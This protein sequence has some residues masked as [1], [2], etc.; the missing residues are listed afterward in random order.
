MAMSLSSICFVF[1]GLNHQLRI[2]SVVNSRRLARTSKLRLLFIHYAENICSSLFSNEIHVNN[3]SLLNLA[4]LRNIY[5]LTNILIFSQTNYNTSIS[6][7][8]LHQ[9]YF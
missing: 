1:M 6:G 8:Y 5:F 9:S 3:N 4:N 2:I 7:S